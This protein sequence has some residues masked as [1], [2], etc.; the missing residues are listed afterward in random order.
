MEASSQQ[1]TPR[2]Q[3]PPVHNNHQL[4]FRILLRE[5]T[6]IDRTKTNLPFANLDT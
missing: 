5:A 3:Q 4:K 2:P 1:I 6:V